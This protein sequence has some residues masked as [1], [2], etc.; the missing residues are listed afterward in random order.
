[1]SSRNLKLGNKARYVD[2]K[3]GHDSVVQ[4]EWYDGLPWGPAW[5][6]INLFLAESLR[7]HYDVKNIVRLECRAIPDTEDEYSMT[8]NVLANDPVRLHPVRGTFKGAKRPQRSSSTNQIVPF[9]V[10]RADSNYGLDAEAMK[11][12]DAFNELPLQRR[13]VFWQKFIAPYFR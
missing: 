2:G 7:E 8:A 1:M 13:I 4:F 6:N 10:S 3:P 5:S 9:E 11:I 12:I